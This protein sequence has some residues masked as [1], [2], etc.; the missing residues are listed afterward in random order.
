MKNLK[1]KE[2]NFEKIIK[3]QIHFATIKSDEKK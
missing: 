1:R 2:Y 3:E